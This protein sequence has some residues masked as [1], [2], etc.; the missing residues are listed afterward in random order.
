L[1]KIILLISFVSFIFASK[2]ISLEELKSYPRSISRDFY[3]WQY[4]DQDISPLQAQKALELIYNMNNK[5]FFKYANKTNSDEIISVAKCMQAK[6][7]KLVKQ[8]DD[9]I[10]NGLSVFKATKLD[11]SQLDTVIQTIKKNYPK[12]AKRYKVLNSSIPFTKLVMSDNDTFFDLFNSCGNEYR[13][14]YFN[15]KLS[16][17]KLK[18]LSKNSTYEFNKML[19]I[20]IT[21]PNLVNLQKSILD[22]NSSKLSLETKFFFGLNLLRYKKTDD[23]FKLFEEVSQKSHTQMDRDKGTFWQ[24]LVTKNVD[25][26]EK[27]SQSKDINIYS[28][29]ALDIMGVV[30]NNI[31]TQLDTNITKISSFDISSPLEWSKVLKAISDKNS[32]QI[33]YYKDI[34]DT[35]DTTPQ[36]SFLLAREDH[37]NYFLRP[38]EKFLEKMDYDRRVLIYAI[39]RQESRFIPSAVSYSYAQGMM[40]IMPFLSESLSFELKDRYDIWN[41]FDY[42]TNIRYANKHLNFLESSLHHPLFIAYAYNGG[43][44]FTKRMLENGYFGVGEYEPF[45]SI[46]IVPLK[47]PREYGKRVLANSVMYRNIYGLPTST[48]RVIKT[49]VSPNH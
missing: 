21:D 5:L 45:M 15:Y 23:A 9:C 19:Q 1:K 39:A 22:V 14:R 28:L 30:P 17:R 33:E 46:E 47:Q 42:K 2:T 41:M 12:E 7:T 32:T 34:F 6:P 37:K 29:Y 36:L 25:F 11:Q 31:V 10:I 43:I 44:G 35:Q 16:N 8:N 24:Y 3:I 4:F 20:I 48:I 40:Q 26:L 27:L 13:R 18:K 49:A 38:Y